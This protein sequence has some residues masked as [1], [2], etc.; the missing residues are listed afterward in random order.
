VSTYDEAAI[1]AQIESLRDTKSAIKQAVFDKG[2]TI[3]EDVP[4]RNYAEAISHINSTTGGPFGITDSLFKLPPEGN[5]GGGMHWSTAWKGDDVAVLIPHAEDPEET[6]E[7]NVGTLAEPDLTEEYPVNP[8]WPNTP[9]YIVKDQASFNEWINDSYEHP[10]DYTIVCILAGNYTCSKQINLSSLN[11]N[12]VFG[13]N[14]AVITSSYGGYLFTMAAKTETDVFYIQNLQVVFNSASAKLS[15]NVYLVRGIKVTCGAS[16]PNVVDIV[17]NYEVLSR[18]YINVVSSNATADKIVINASGT[19]ISDVTVV[20]ERYN[21][22]AASCGYDYGFRKMA[23]TTHPTT[24]TRCYVLG[25]CRKSGIDLGEYDD[26]TI[27][28]CFVQRVVSRQVSN[29]TLDVYGFR[30]PVIKKCHLYSIGVMGGTSTGYYQTTVTKFCGFSGTTI[31]DSKITTANL[32]VYFTGFYATTIKRC[33]IVNASIVGFLYGAVSL[34]Y[35]KGAAGL[36]EECV[37]YSISLGSAKIRAAG[38]SFAINVF[39]G[40]SPSDA[41][42]SKNI[43]GRCILD[44]ANPG[45]STANLPLVVFQ[46]FKSVED[47]IIGSIYH[48]VY[49]GQVTISQSNVANFLRNTIHEITVLST[50]TASQTVQPLFYVQKTAD[51]GKIAQNRVGRIVIHNTSDAYTAGY[52]I[53]SNNFHEFTD[54]TFASINVS[55]DVGDVTTALLYTAGSAATRIERNIFHTVNFSKSMPVAGKTSI[56]L[57]HCQGSAAGPSITGNVI[58]DAR[59]KGYITADTSANV[60]ELYGIRAEGKTEIVDNYIRLKLDTSNSIAAAAANGFL[61]T[62]DTATLPIQYN[63]VYGI[64]TNLGTCHISKNNVGVIGEHTT[65]AIYSAATGNPGADV[66]NNDNSIFA[67]NFNR[68]LGTYDIAAGFVNINKLTKSRMIHEHTVQTMYT[69]CT[70]ADNSTAPTVENGDNEI[71]LLPIVEIV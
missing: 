53:L 49:T 8:N 55:V 11:T 12:K 61:M 41:V 31:E 1:L 18:A 45:A 42:C 62:T 2:V 48:S 51:N 25:T 71:P 67:E 56:S 9:T 16:Y 54:N 39:D 19:T 40:N 64:Y 17:N 14:G 22:T 20:I 23:A 65:Y 24:L 50:A 34:F 28:R 69:T 30:A 44:D 6:I 32:S 3:G 47:C 26:G 13:E 4:F 21:D 5:Y 60:Q 15:N 43:L 59:A 36:L 37:V 52:A 66:V 38:S 10:R 33:A 68:T 46:R 35:L 58:Y 70:G 57:I 7:F 63:Y 29:G 27:D